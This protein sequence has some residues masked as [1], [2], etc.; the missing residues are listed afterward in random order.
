MQEH[1]VRN[2]FPEPL[3]HKNVV[4]EAVIGS[5]ASQSFALMPLDAHI[6]PDHFGETGLRAVTRAENTR[7]IEQSLD[8]LEYA[9]TSD[10]PLSYGLNIGDL[11]LFGYGRDSLKRLLTR[12][13]SIINTLEDAY[14]FTQK[15]HGELIAVRPLPDRAFFWISMTIAKNSS[16]DDGMFD[17]GFSFDKQPLGF[18]NQLKE[19]YD[20]SPFVM[21]RSFREFEF[22]A[23]QVS[24]RWTTEPIRYQTDTQVQFAEVE[25][26]VPNGGGQIRDLAL[27]NSLPLAVRDEDVGADEL[28]LGFASVLDVG[29][30]RNTGSVL[31]THGFE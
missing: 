20:E 5:E 1:F 15:R 26:L 31:L 25:N 7:E 22:G 9:F 18:R 13:E 16:I 3:D 23:S 24:G 17:I 6:S 12:Y 30:P 2:E 28:Q 29:I 4:Q 11:Q 14:E 8:A 10:S 27:F 19:F 21:P